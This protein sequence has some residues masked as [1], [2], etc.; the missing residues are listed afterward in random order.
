MD[1]FSAQP[2]TTV[3]K[4]Y[5]YLSATPEALIA[6]HLPPREFGYYLAVGTRK[7]MRDQA[8]FFS[9]DMEKIENLPEDYMNERLVPYADGEPKPSV[10]ISINNSILSRP[11]WPASSALRISF[12]I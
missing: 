8:I 12:G 6:S 9:L 7:R 1:P 4:R 11:G 3:M 10:S 2:K 5:I